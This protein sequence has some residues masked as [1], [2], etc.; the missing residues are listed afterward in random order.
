MS[1]LKLLNAI[2]SGKVKKQKTWSR[3][4]PFELFTVEMNSASSF[5]CL[6]FAFNGIF[7]CDKKRRTRETSPRVPRTVIAELN[8]NIIEFLGP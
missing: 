7:F 3:S 5:I 2:S 6:W 1:E 8:T 4:S